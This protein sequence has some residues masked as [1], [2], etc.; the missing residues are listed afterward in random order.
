LYNLPSD[1]PDSWN[2]SHSPVVFDVWQSV[3]WMDVS[4]STLSNFF[5]QT[6][7]FHRI[8]QLKLL[9]KSSPQV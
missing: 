6:C 5:P 9:Y 7:P 1:Y 2:I 3:V 4:R 8:F